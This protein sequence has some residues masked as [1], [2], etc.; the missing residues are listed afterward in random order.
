MFVLLINV[1]VTLLNPGFVISDL[2]VLSSPCLLFPPCLPF[3]GEDG[4]VGWGIKDEEN[5]R[6]KID[7]TGKETKIF[8]D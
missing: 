8:L 5:K 4:E 2:S 3:Q 7:K 6:G 1:S